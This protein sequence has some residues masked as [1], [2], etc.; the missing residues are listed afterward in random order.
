VTVL[1]IETATTVCGAALVR[2]GILLGEAFLDARNVHAERLLE[3]IDEVLRGAGCRPAT[4]GG[5]AVSSGPGSFTGLRI[6]MS[7]AKGLAYAGDVPLVGVSTLEALARRVAARAG[8]LP[9]ETI[10]A[11]LDARRDEV[12]CQL[13]RAEAGDVTPDGDVADMTVADLRVRIA[14]R[15][16]LAAGDGAVKV[17]GPEGVREA[18]WRVAS[19]EDGACSAA[20]VALLGARMLSAGL[21]D[22]PVT[23]EPRY[24]KEFFL[25]TP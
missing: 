16:V 21:R 14:G 6:G 22:D 1:G 19:G 20:E 24:I 7:V 25:R 15:R 3:Q 4:L 12:Y 17:T 2:D 23:L 11:A 18:G 8:V 5:V 10:L 13:F 9:G